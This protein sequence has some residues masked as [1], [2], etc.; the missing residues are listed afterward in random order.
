MSV[1]KKELNDRAFPNYE[2]GSTLITLRCHHG[3]LISYTPHPHYED[4]DACVIDYV[5]SIGLSVFEVDRLTE[6]AGLY[7]HKLGY[8]PYQIGENEGADGNDNLNTPN[9]NRIGEGNDNEANR[10]NNNDSDSG[11]ES[12][13]STVDSDY[14]MTDSDDNELHDNVHKNAEW[15]DNLVM[16]E[17]N[18]VAPSSESDFETVNE[19]DDEKTSSECR[20]FNPKNIDNPKLELKMLFSSIKECKLAIT[21]Y[22]VRQGRTCKFV[23]QDKI[24]LRAKC[25]SEGYDWLIYAAKLSGEGSVQIKTFENTHKCGFTYDNPLVNSGWVGKKA[26]RKAMKI[27]LG[28]EIDKYSKLG[29]YMHEIQ[30]SNPGNSIILKTVDESANGSF[31]KRSVGGVLLIAVGLDANNSIY[32]IAYAVT[33]GDNKESWAWFFKLLKEDLK[34]KRDYKWTIMSDKQKGLI[35]ACDNV[36]S[37]PV[38]RFC[39]KHMHGNFSSAGFKEETLRK[40]LWA[41]AKAT[42]STKFASKMEEMAAIDIHATKWFDDKPPSQWSR[43]Y[44]SI[45]PKCDILLNNMCEYFNNKIL[46][47]REKP[48]IE[49]LELLRLYM[50]QRMQQNMDLAQ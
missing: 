18:D 4:G 27:I 23:K 21:N 14:N 41:A 16:P 35:Q 49:M 6:S 2:Q 3:G 8:D 5:E 19:H 13:F 9:A 17:D 22:S 15:D 20:V 1:R 39:V 11:S 47:A 26:R 31:L 32:P 50:M 38:H 40:A 30:K 48:I 29:A 24:R 45:Y 10:N 34:I 44:F 33:E 43:A 12:F 36:F 42:T 25:R 37:N 46:D 7:G 28:S